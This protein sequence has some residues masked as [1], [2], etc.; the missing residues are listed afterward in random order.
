MLVKKVFADLKSAIKSIESNEIKNTKDYT[1]IRGKSNGNPP[2]TVQYGIDQLSE[3]KEVDDA[4]FKEA[5]KVA[6]FLLSLK[7]WYY[8]Q[9]ALGFVS[10]EDEAEF[11][12]KLRLAVENLNIAA[13]P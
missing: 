7:T 1:E 9:V 3:G 8:S 6:N 11:Q 10:P 5:V 13:E 12:R 2:A 4:K